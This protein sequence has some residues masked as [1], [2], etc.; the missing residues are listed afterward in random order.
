M[1]GG[2][3]I[4]DM[5]IYRD[6]CLLVIYVCMC[7]WGGG[8]STPICVYGSVCLLVIYICLKITT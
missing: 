4:G 1:E 3:P 7:V 6:M 8:D 5:C 2:G